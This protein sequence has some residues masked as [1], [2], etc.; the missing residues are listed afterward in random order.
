MH[1]KTYMFAFI[2]QVFEDAEFH[3]QMEKRQGRRRRRGSSPKKYGRNKIT[4]TL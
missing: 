1:V 2:L 3:H 4:V